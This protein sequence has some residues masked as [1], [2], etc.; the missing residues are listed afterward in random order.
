MSE[1][2]WP[3]NL[4]ASGKSPILSWLGLD[5]CFGFRYESLR[6]PGCCSSREKAAFAYLYSPFSTC[7]FS[8]AETSFFVPRRNFL[9]LFTSRTRE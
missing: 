8:W 1:N 9:W 4:Y 7:F 2:I 3:R 5:P 6:Y